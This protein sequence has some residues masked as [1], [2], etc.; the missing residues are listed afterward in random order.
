LAQRSAALQ[1]ARR[2][3]TSQAAN[4]FQLDWRRG[5]RETRERDEEE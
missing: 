2:A 5:R 1:Q 4:A 3:A